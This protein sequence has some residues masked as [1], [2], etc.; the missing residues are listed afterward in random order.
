M[1]I[2]YEATFPN[3]DKA[4]IRQILK[5]LGAELLRAEFMQKRVVFNLPK[6]HE[7]KGGW[8]RVRDEGDQITLSLKII[9]GSRIEDQ[10]EI[11]LKIDDFK[12]AEMF[13]ENIGAEKKAYQESKREKWLLDGVEVTLDEWPFLEPYIELE[14][15]SA[16]SVKK[17]SEKL[18]FDYS[19]AIFDSVDA[20]YS[21]KYDVSKD[22]INNHTPQI[23]FSGKNPFLAEV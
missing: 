7:I 22:R 8:L 14:G 16:Q 19:K 11:C 12:Q 1:D 21:Q 5:Q 20:Q 3:I 13:L 6:G 23:T 4:K 17:V 9:D 10:K 18:G 15:T 2:E